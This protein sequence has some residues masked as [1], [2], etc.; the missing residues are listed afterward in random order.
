[1]RRTVPGDAGGLH[2]MREIG[3]REKITWEM[4]S[5]RGAFSLLGLGAVLGVAV[6]TTVLTTSEAEA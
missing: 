2:N 3:M 1:M 4:I 6:P 5:R